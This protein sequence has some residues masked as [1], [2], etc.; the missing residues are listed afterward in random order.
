M[1]LLSPFVE[2]GDGLID[3]ELNTELA[4]VLMDFGFFTLLQMS[5]LCIF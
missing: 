5:L 2:V 3:P 1:D 4:T